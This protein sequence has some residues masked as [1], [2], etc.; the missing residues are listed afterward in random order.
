MAIDTDSF[1]DSKINAAMKELRAAH[2]TQIMRKQWRNFLAI[3]RDIA[4]GKGL[5]G[6]DLRDYMTEAMEACD[7]YLY[8]MFAPNGDYRGYTIDGEQYWQ[9]NDGP[10]AA[11]SLAT[12]TFADIRRGIDLDAGEQLSEIVEAQ[13]KTE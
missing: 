12:C 9:G 8:V 13:T 4:R 7:L 1:I 2:I 11:I 3:N 10:S 5:R 6:K